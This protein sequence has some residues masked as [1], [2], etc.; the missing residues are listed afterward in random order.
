MEL[1]TID[2]AGLEI[3][4]RLPDLR[5]DIHKF[6]EYVRSREIKR[7]HRGNNLGK[8]DT[9]RLAKLVS[10]PDAAKEVDEEGS[11]A[12]VDYLDQLVLRLGFVRYD[13]KGE[14]AGYTSQE[15]S[16]PDNYIE[17]M[18]T[19]YARFLAAKAAQQETTLLEAAAQGSPG[20]GQRVLSDERAG[21]AGRVQH[22]GIGDRGDAHPRFRGR[23]PF[24]VAVPWR[25]APPASG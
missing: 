11:S 24:P 1:K 5:R 18:E 23:P 7:S 4:T 19:P 6:V 22:L 2:V 10:D 13:T 8:A 14:Y 21:A 15:P 17:F 3:P 16:F 9:K 12:W 20:R 25:S